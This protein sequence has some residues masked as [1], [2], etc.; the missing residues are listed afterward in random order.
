MP[1]DPISLIYVDNDARSRQ[2]MQNE[3]ELH[4]SNPITYIATGEELLARLARKEIVDPGIILIDLELPEMNGFQVVSS[5]RE[6]HKNLDR[7]PLII[8][9]GSED[10]SHVKSSKEVGANAYIVKPVTVF[11]LMHVLKRF[12]RYEL[13]IMDRRQVPEFAMKRTIAASP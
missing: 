6:Q 3:I 2:R 11:S 4:I 1:N 12:G 8:V 5:I 10:K 9:A 13:Q 7:T